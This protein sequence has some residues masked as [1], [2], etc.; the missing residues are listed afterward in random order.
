[1]ARPTYLLV[2][3]HRSESTLDMPTFTVFYTLSLRA[4]L[5]NG[6]ILLALLKYPL[7]IQRHNSTTLI[8][9]YAVYRYTYSPYLHLRHSFTASIKWPYNKMLSNRGELNYK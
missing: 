7:R 8:S 9:N 1:M 3:Y 6:Y 2:S 4:W 5:T